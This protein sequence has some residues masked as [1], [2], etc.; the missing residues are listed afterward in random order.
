MDIYEW[1]NQLEQSGLGEWLR[2]TVRAIPVINSLHVIGLVL[3]F[4]TISVVDLRLLGIPSTR[5]S[6]KLLAGE[7][8]KWTWLAFALA[9]VTGFLMF[10]A[11]ATTFYDNTQ[12]RIKMVLL[13]LAG[14]NMLVFELITVRSVH[15]WDKDQPVPVSAKVAGLLSLVL[16]MGVIVFGRWVGYTKGAHID[17]Q[18]IDFNAIN[19][20]FF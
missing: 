19:S 17:V 4:G 11:N 12:F 6:F 7:L 3:V 18:S 1:A 5:R 16:W 13:V 8:L 10:T 2:S 14:I 20:P 9:V 15:Q